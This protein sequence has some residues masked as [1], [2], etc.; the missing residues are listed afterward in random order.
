M[1]P[2]QVVIAEKILE[3]YQ[4]EDFYKVMVLTN[5]S[6]KY[7]LYKERFFQKNKYN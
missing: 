4:D 7:L 6:S 3:K 5:L 1:T 2:L